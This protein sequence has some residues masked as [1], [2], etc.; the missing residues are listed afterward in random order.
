MHAVAGVLFVLPGVA[1]IMALSWI[2]ALY[3]D[4]RAV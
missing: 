1:A 4:V 3:G 2:Y